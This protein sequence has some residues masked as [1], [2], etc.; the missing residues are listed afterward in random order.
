MTR[1]EFDFII[2]GIGEEIKSP[3]PD[4]LRTMIWAIYK[5]CDAHYFTEHIVS[6]LKAIINK[7]KEFFKHSNS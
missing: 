7:D 3:C 6:A 2:D 1:R 5:D 4:N